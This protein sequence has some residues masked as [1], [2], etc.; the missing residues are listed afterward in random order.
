MR[1]KTVF[2]FIISSKK[3]VSYASK[4]GYYINFCANKKLSAPDGEHLHHVMDKLGM[5]KRPRRFSPPEAV[6]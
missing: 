3:T 6:L 2:L 4:R 5:E 1:A